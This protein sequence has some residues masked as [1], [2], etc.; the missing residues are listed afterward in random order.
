MI[1]LVPLH[2]AG[3]I[4]AGLY[5]A[6]PVTVM[7]N[8]KLPTALPNFFFAFSVAL[9]PQCVVA[10]STKFKWFDFRLLV[11]ANVWNTSLLKALRMSEA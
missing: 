2:R 4:L 10:H 5:S 3:E 7:R 9:R 1:G 6:R 11:F 8:G